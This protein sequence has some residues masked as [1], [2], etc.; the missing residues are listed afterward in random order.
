MKKKVTTR[1]MTLKEIAKGGMRNIKRKVGDMRL[2]K[3][4]GAY[5]SNTIRE[6]Y[7][8]MS[9]LMKKAPGVGKPKKK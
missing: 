6:T 7:Q 1:S 9:K 4:A 3:A 8:T 2:G 5:K